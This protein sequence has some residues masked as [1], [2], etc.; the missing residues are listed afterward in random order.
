M[1]N[2]VQVSPRSFLATESKRDAYS[3]LAKSLLNLTNCQRIR[4]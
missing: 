2:S 3:A 1:S 4:S